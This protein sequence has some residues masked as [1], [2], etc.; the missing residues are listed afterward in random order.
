VKHG[1]TLPP[2]CNRIMAHRLRLRHSTD[3]Q[4]GEAMRFKMMLPTA[5]ILT[6]LC[7]HQALAAPVVVACG[8]GQH[9]I[10]R[11]TFVRG[12][13]V[14]KVQCVGYHA[15][16]R[17]RSWGKTA[18]IIGGGAGT[19]AGIGGLVHGKKGAL[20]GAALGGG[21]ASLYEGAHRR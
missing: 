3:F 4:E 11:D 20:I 16:R 17:H 7:G 15:V 12:E 1:E 10:V 8:P 13:P 2:A 19:G 5:A 18:L 6:C 14:T 9:T 21:V